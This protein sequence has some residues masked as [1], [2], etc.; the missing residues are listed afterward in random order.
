LRTA[1]ANGVEIK[2]LHD[3]LNLKEE[4]LIS[5]SEWNITV[6]Y[7]DSLFC[8]NNQND[9]SI[10]L[11][12]HGLGKSLLLT[13]DLEKHGERELLPLDIKSDVLKLGH[14]GSKTSNTRFFLE[15][16]DPTHAIISAALR[17]RYR[18]PSKEVLE[19]LDSLG[20]ERSGTY[21]KGSI[22]VEFSEGAVRF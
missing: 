10:V 18:H 16:V 12:V 1:K 22:R 20:I 21:E 7:P 4:M 15:Q 8:N 11:K 13:G 19:R 2:N 17:N 3:G 9:N 14:H 5:K 6:L